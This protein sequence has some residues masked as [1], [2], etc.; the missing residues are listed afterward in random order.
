MGFYYYSFQCVF[1]SSELVCWIRVLIFDWCSKYSQ[2]FVWYR[3]TGFCFWN[4]FCNLFNL[5]F[6]IAGHW[7]CLNLFCCWFGNTSQENGEFTIELDT[8]LWYVPWS[9][10]YPYPPSSQN[11]QER[12]V[13]LRYFNG[14]KPFECIVRADNMLYMWV[15]LAPLVF[16]LLFSEF[17]CFVK[18]S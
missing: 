4:K 3:V 16:S 14:P 6:S 18:K 11:E 12:M 17:L 5:L 9:S 8:P 7:I 13:F 10:V 2:Q 15:S 1:F